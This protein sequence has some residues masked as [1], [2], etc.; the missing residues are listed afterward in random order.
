[1]AKPQ[2]HTKI[3]YIL[4]VKFS[5]DVR[6]QPTLKYMGQYVLLSQND[7]TCTSDK[8]KFTKWSDSLKMLIV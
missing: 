3:L 8:K 6:E 7:G 1:M 5:D 4:N 2:E